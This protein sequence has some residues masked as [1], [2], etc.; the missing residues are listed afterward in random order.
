MA[1]E[2]GANITL[3]KK[4]NRALILK[5]ISMEGNLSRVELASITGLAKMTITNLV[6]ELIEQGFLQEEEMERGG[7]PAKQVG[8]PAIRLKLADH[9]PCICGMLIK[10]GLCQVALADFS[11][12]FF[13][14][15]TYHY[16]DT[17]T[18][19]MLIG[20]LV[21]NFHTLKKRTS[22][23]VVA[24][25]ISSMG[26]VDTARGYLLNPPAFYGI[27]DLPIVARIERETGLRTFLINDANAGALAEKMYGLGKN[28]KNFVYLHIMKGVG[29]GLILSDKLYEGNVGQSG[30]LGHMSINF[31]GPVCTCGQSGCVEVYANLNNMVKQAQSMSKYYGESRILKLESPV[32]EDFVEAAAEGDQLATTCLYDFCRY[33]AYALINTLNMLDI[34]LVV[35]GYYSKPGT[36]IVENMLRQ[37]I[38]TSN[39]YK[40]KSEIQFVHS[41][42][43]GDA[44]L[45]GS[46]AAVA[47]RYFDLKF[48]I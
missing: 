10:R 19:E 28:I 18:E 24:V 38:T 34:E 48:E 3:V 37:I 42:F 33:I 26:P 43:L 11:G 14:Q 16:S 7:E 9:S 31:F 45:V 39:R 17:L 13:D 47:D 5:T 41:S 20:V 2:K 44:P 35:V 23:K 22:R 32:W 46:V 36:E 12:K 30:E 21:E 27:R 8:R 25:G 6:S 15:I 4:Q 29:S 40:Q 1:K